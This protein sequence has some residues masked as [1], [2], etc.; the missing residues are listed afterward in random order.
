[1]NHTHY[2][3]VAY[4]A[5]FFN[6]VSAI[7]HVSGS[8]I[9]DLLLRSSNATRYFK[10]DSREIYHSIVKLQRRVRNNVNGIINDL[11]ARRVF[12]D[13]VARRGPSIPFRR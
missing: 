1:M 5:L 9:E 6:T 10:K 13:R 2:F 7:D 4:P 3:E 12:P 11:S 8:A